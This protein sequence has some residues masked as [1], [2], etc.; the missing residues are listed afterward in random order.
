MSNDRDALIIFVKNPLPGQVKTRIAASLGAHQAYLI[1]LQLLATIRETSLGVEVDKYVFYSDF[2]DT[3]DEWPSPPF[4][5]HRQ[6]G[7]DIGAR[8]DD[9]LSTILCRHPRAVLIG[10]DVPEIYPGLIREAFQQLAE[11][12]VVLGPAADGGYYLL[13]LSRPQP[14]LFRGIQWSTASVLEETLHICRNHA[15]PVKLLETLPDIDTAA[16]W[17][18]YICRKARID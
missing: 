2:I 13:G 15:L 7:A 8:M 4:Q 10:S 6:S 1:Y 14:A 18:S 3:S 12:P 17:F 16:D 5:K 9:A 11:V